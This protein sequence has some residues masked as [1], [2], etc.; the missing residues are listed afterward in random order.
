MLAG[1]WAEDAGGWLAP[2]MLET[3]G[4]ANWTIQLTAIISS[5][6][7]R[8]AMAGVITDSDAREGQEAGPKPG[9]PSLDL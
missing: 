1:T 8:R 9:S 4:A 7:L 2:A 3:A 5:L 6:W